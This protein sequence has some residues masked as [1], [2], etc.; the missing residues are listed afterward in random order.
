MPCLSRSSRL[1]AIRA[2]RLTVARSI[3]YDQYFSAVCLQRRPKIAP[4]LNVVQETMKQLLAKREVA[5]SLF[6]DHEL[7]HFEDL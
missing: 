4:P 2:S 3:S 5:L 7:R 1:L 6:S